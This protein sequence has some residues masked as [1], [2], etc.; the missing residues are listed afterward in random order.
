MDVFKVDSGFRERV[1]SGFLDSEAL[2]EI[3]HLV[4]AFKL[5][6]LEDHELF[7]FGRHVLHNHRYFTD[8]QARLNDTVSRHAGED[9]EPS[10]NF[11]SFYNDLGI[12]EPHMDAP[13]SKWTLDICLEQ[14][15]PW[16]LY[17]SNTCSWQSDEQIKN[18]YTPDAI[19]ASQDFRKHTLQPGDAV[20]FGGSSQ[21]HYRDRIPRVMPKNFCTLIFLHYIPAGTGQLSDP[22]RWPDIFGVPDLKEIIEC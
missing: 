21:W 16:P 18:S 1:F 6:E 11:L 4:H 17:I 7:S 12:C 15:S 9:V 8:L 22:K 13:V 20:L 5:D 3:T 10:Y 19:K 14:S 2:R